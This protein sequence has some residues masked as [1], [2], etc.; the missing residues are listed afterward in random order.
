MTARV[1]AQLQSENLRGQGGIHYRIDLGVDSKPDQDSLESFKQVMEIT[2]DDLVRY[3]AGEFQ[4]Y[5]E[6]IKYRQYAEEHGFSSATVTA[7]YNQQEIPIEDA[8]EFQTTIDTP[9][10]VTHISDRENDIYW[11]S[12]RYEIQIGVYEEEQDVDKLIALGDVKT[13]VSD[14]LIYYTFGEFKTYLEAKLGKQQIIDAGFADAFLIALLEGEKVLV[15]EAIIFEA[16]REQMRQD[17]L[18]KTG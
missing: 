2:A 9:E 6:A 1:I 17:E 13:R 10:E 7:F 12:L 18:G 8:I 3:H 16:F 11:R 4:N 14:G 5:L 15:E